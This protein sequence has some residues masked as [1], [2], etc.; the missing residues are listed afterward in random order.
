MSACT[1]CGR[2]I[3][4]EEQIKSFSLASKPLIRWLRKNAHPHCTAVVTDNRAEL[5]EGI[6]GV[7]ADEFLDEEIVRMT[8]GNDTSRPIAP[9]RFVPMDFRDKCRIVADGGELGVNLDPYGLYC[10]RIDSPLQA[11]HYR[12]NSDSMWKKC[13][14]EVEE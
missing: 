11:T 3:A 7:P 14:K 6:M 12:P 9:K 5:V 8:F 2:M 1:V 10:M 4:T 13:E